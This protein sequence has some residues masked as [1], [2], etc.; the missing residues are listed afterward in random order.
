MLISRRKEGEAIHIG[1]DIEIRIVSVRGN[2]VT[3]G[4]VAPRNVKISNRKMSEIEM[5][6]TMSSHTTAAAH[7]AQIGHLLRPAADRAE[8]IVFLL[9]RTSTEKTPPS[10][11]KGN[12]RSDE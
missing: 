3:L 9:E 11:D 4:I 7:S 8:D 12:G 6:N 5:A 1:E 2:K 10:D